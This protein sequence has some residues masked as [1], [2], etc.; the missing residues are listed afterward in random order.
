MNTL[1]QVITMTTSVCQIFMYSQLID[2][3]VIGNINTLY[4]VNKLTIFLL[5]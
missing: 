1:K 4:Y 3:S 5:D 2:G